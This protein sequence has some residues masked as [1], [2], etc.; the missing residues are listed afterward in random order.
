MF[1]LVRSKLAFGL[2]EIILVDFNSYNDV[3]QENR[4]IADC[5]RCYNLDAPYCI[6]IKQ[7][8]EMVKEE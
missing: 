7:L 1:M 2:I 3:L 4:Y 6:N 8:K 5:R